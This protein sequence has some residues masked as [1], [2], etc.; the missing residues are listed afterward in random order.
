M[1]G[2]GFRFFRPAVYQTTW[3][4]PVYASMFIM[5]ILC[6]CLLPLV[7]CC[8]E[9]CG[10]LLRSSMLSSLNLVTRVAEPAV[11]CQNTPVT[12]SEHCWTKSTRTCGP[13]VLDQT[14][15]N[16]WE[17]RF[18]SY[19]GSSCG[20]NALNKLFLKELFDFFWSI[21]P[22]FGLFCCHAEVVCC[23]LV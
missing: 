16:Q 1:G 22:P 11:P 8:M 10:P 4:V 3:R 12:L 6:C 5:S 17:H 20:Q 2:R 23:C 18:I 15:F 7:C 13:R 19:F 21:F 14:R 9:A